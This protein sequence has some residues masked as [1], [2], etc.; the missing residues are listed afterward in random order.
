MRYLS[1][2]AVKLNG[3]EDLATSSFVNWET[4]FTI[5]N[6]SIAATE[7]TVTVPINFSAFSE[8]GVCNQ[9]WHGI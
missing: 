5:E 2:C 1:S 6:Q 7:S 3:W 9:H 8:L 4:T